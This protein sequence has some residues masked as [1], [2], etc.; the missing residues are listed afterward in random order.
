MGMSVFPFRTSLSRSPV[1]VNEDRGEDEEHPDQGHDVAGMPG[2][3]MRPERHLAD[4]L[5]Q[6][7]SNGGDARGQQQWPEERQPALA[8][9]YD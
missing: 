4:G 9:V 6:A 1:S 7:G 5:C 2:D 3:V 8:S